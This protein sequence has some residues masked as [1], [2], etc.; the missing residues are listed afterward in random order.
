MQSILRP[1]NREGGN[2]KQ[3]KPTKRP[4][5]GEYEMLHVRVVCKIKAYKTT[6]RKHQSKAPFVVRLFLMHLYYHLHF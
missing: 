3:G 6:H 1:D 4:T 2:L 5:P